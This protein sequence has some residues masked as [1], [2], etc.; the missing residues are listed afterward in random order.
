MWHKGKVKEK[1]KYK[2]IKHLFKKNLLG[3]KQLNNP[4]GEERNKNHDLG[5]TCTLRM[6]WP[7]L[8]QGSGQTSTKQAVGTAVTPTNGDSPP[9][10][11]H[12][13]HTPWLYKRNWLTINYSH[14]LL[15]RTCVVIAFHPVTWRHH[16]MWEWSCWN[17]FSSV[18]FGGRYGVKVL[19]WTFKLLWLR[20]IWNLLIF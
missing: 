11:H 18:C 17:P 19:S 14:L 16:I 3:T 20:F 1:T 4:K 9:Y 2:C 12:L 6:F 15:N 13:P 10:L 5:K 8:L 7:A